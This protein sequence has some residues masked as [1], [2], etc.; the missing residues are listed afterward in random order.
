MAFTGNEDHSISLQDAAVLTK[1][2]RDSQTTLDYIK[3]E[4]FGKQSIL[5]ILNQANCV[6]IRVYYGVEN[7]AGINTP[8]LVIC[9]ATSDENDMENGLLAEK[10]MTLPPSNTLN[11]S[12]NSTI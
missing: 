4:F 12:L 9:G 1:N 10:G 11:N 7:D 3:G 8:H 5:N 6:G 2:Y